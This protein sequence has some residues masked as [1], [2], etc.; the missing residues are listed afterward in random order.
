MPSIKYF[1]NEGV[2]LRL[3]DAQKLPIPGLRDGE[4]IPQMPVGAQRAS[5][6][7]LVCRVSLDLRH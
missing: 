4:T 6:R 1:S 3:E 5:L 7:I 2:G